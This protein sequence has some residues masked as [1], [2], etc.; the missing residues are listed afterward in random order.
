[1][2]SSRAPTSAN[3]RWQLECCVEKDSEAGATG[4]EVLIDQNVCRGL[5]RDT[6]V[7]MPD[8]LGLPAAISSPGAAASGIHRSETSL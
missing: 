8:F 5:G 1:M 6:V 3:R 4:D 2:V 7:H